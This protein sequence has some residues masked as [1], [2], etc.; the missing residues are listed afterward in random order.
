MKLIIIIFLIW[1]I[2]ACVKVS[3]DSNTPHIEVH[4]NKIDNDTLYMME[5]IAYGKEKVEE[6]RKQ[7]RY[8]KGSPN[9][10]AMS[11]RSEISADILK[12]LGEDE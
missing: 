11:E 4:P 10:C 12:N 3:L 9:Y 1:V 8:T 6:W 5:F 7:G 2:A